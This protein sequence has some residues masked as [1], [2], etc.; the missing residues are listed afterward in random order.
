MTSPTASSQSMMVSFTFVILAVTVTVQA[1]KSTMPTTEQPVPLIYTEV[2]IGNTAELTCDLKSSV[3]GD[4]VLLVLWYKDGETMPF[5]SVDARGKYMKDAQH[6][7]DDKMM[8]YGR[9][10]L[11]ANSD[12]V[13][14]L[15]EPVLREDEG[16]YK[17]RVDFKKSPTRHYRIHLAVITPASKPVITDS[18]GIEVRN[19]SGLYDSGTPLTLIC[20][21]TQGQPVP[22]VIWY[23]DGRA[24]E[25]LL[26]YLPNKQIRNVLHIAQL[27]RAN[28][29]VRY[30]CAASNSRIL[31]PLVSAITIL[32]RLPLLEV[33]IEKESRAVSANKPQQVTCRAVGSSPPPHI[34]WWKAGSRLQASHETTSSDG[35]IS[36]SS[37]TFV[38]SAEDGGQYLTCRAE[39]HE[40][41]ASVMEDTLKLDVQYVPVVHL[42]LGSKLQIAAIKE[43]DDVYMECNIRA[44]PWVTKVTWKHNGRA[45]QQNSSAGII[46]SNQS[47]VLQRIDRQTAGIYT[48]LA[49]NIEGQG[50]SNALALPVKFRPHCQPGQQTAYGASR[51]EAV[52]IRCAVDAHPATDLSFRWMFN[53]TLA[54]AE[55]PNGSISTSGWQSNVTH[56]VY[57]NEQQDYGT[58][59]C[60]AR[61]AIGE[62]RDPCVFSIQPAGEPSAP[63][64]CT[65][66][67]ITSNGLSVNC[68]PG[69]DGG[70][71]QFFNLQV[72][73]A[74]TDN[75][76]VFNATGVQSGDFGVYS[77]EPATS[78][79]LHIWAEN[80][81]GRSSSV[82][83]MAE[84]SISQAVERRAG[85]VG[86]TT[87]AV[88]FHMTPI[89]GALIGIVATLI[90]VA[91]AIVFI[92]RTRERDD[93]T[94]NGSASKLSVNTT[95]TKSVSQLNVEPGT[96]GSITAAKD[97]TSGKRDSVGNVLLQQKH[98]DEHNPDVVPNK[99]D[100]NTRNVGVSTISMAGPINLHYSAAGEPSSQVY[101][102]AAYTPSHLGYATATEHDVMLSHV[103]VPMML[104]MR[105]D[106]STSATSSLTRA[107]QLPHL[108]PSHS[109]DHQFESYPTTT[110]VA[111]TYTVGSHTSGKGV[112]VSPGRH[113]SHRH[114]LHHHHHPLATVSVI[115]EE[116]S[117]VSTPLMSS[118][119]SVS[120]RVINPRESAV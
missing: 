76:A 83:L 69:Y 101:V 14:L 103:T 31:P 38:A 78:Y 63:Y 66:N 98:E 21:V 105:S 25:G 22:R 37:L 89:L 106:G 87:Q 109:T 7:S 3:P 20:T 102:S 82:V 53:S 86:P 51:N 27:S 19:V 6:W 10:H 73:Q 18:K 54:V 9:A 104:M 118:Q 52:T 110:A 40:L 119:G 88:V 112:I 113:H 71:T 56:R 80:T 64:N 55:V 120:P 8:L 28:H 85:L 46:M 84:T 61:N 111:G 60:W 117:T 1:A 2:I 16:V 81:K 94:P 12:K 4:Y 35:N 91:V 24:I 32:M 39:N 30:S 33:K 92:V 5:Y 41:P 70:L 17:C 47:L 97:S 107:G 44:H 115:E 68:L 34:S 99:N 50:E 114:H 62:Q 36:Y 29:N 96:T 75:K 49:T 15:L 116:L 26:E 59:L 79:E 67:N 57:Q 95:Q 45:L 48:C 77:L 11:K 65:V 58:L 23:E 90:I 72:L 108:P 74:K 13:R 43:G 100:S 42:E 93:G